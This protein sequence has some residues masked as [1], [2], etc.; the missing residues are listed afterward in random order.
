MAIGIHVRRAAAF[1]DIKVQM[2]LRT[3]ASVS[4]Q[5]YGLP[6]S[7]CFIQLHQCTQRC[8]VYVAAFGGIIVFDYNIVLFTWNTGSIT[9]AFL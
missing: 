9:E 2:R 1:P 6:L 4:A 5:A 3:V 8:Q 7:Y